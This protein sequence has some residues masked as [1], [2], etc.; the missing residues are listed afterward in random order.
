MYCSLHFVCVDF[1]LSSCCL[2][3]R[4][5][6]LNTVTVHFR[7]SS[8]P[9]FLSFF[10]GHSVP[11]WISFLNGK[12]PLLDMRRI[13]V[14]RFE[15][16]SSL[17]GRDPGLLGHAHLVVRHLPRLRVRCS[18]QGRVRWPLGPRLR[19]LLDLGLQA[20]R[21]LVWQG[22]VLG[23]AASTIQPKWVKLLFF[24]SFFSLFSVSLE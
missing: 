11:L 13:T 7:S 2:E 3:V 9:R 20:G 17:G 12:Q 6:V 1:F 15:R 23:A 19:G 8:P 10:V 21:H 18:P 5:F 22:Q 14:Q 16:A 24:F 4:V